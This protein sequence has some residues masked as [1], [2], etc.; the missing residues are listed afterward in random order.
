MAVS[1]FMQLLG[2]WHDYHRGLWEMGD[3]KCSRRLLGIW[4]A[5]LHS[6]AGKALRHF[7]GKPRLPLEE[8]HGAKGVGQHHSSE[9]YRDGHRERDGSVCKVGAASASPWPRP[10]PEALHRAARHP[11]WRRYP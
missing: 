9:L 11:Q 7:A 10:S 2:E 6:R 1:I 3:W 5:A 4:K 8:K